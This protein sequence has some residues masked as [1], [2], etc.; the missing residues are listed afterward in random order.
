M[1]GIR[2]GRVLLA[3]L[4]AGLVLFAAEAVING[5]VLGGEWHRV[6]QAFGVGVEHTAG[7]FLTFVAISL[8]K[9]VALVASYAVAREVLGAGARTAAVVG[10]VIWLVS[11]AL[12]WATLAPMGLPRRLVLLAPLLAVLGTV[13][14]ALAGA[15]AYD[16]GGVAHAGRVRASA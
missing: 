7:G 12:P 5:A 3:G 14:A 9:G 6:T 13:A 11:S 10:M 15:W 1:N 2:W 4:A 8:V 16:R